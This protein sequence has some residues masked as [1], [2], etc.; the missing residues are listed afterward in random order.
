MI[1]ES[2][3]G[4]TAYGYTRAQAIADGV[5]HDVSAM[6]A[7]VG[8]KCPVYITASIYSLCVVEFGKIVG[9]GEQASLER[10]L[11][12]VLHGLIHI[13]KP[14]ITSRYVAANDAGTHLGDAIMV[15]AHCTQDVTNEIPAITVMAPDE[16]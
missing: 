7:K 4:S 15:I 12:T 6:A 10:F 13:P 3:Y 8:I 14:R 16:D 11:G 9:L 1:P 2:V 5:Q